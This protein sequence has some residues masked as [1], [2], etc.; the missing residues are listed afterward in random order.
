MIRIGLT[1]QITT[2]ASCVTRLHL[3]IFLAAAAWAQDPF[4][5][6]ETLPRGVWT[7]ETHLN[8]VPSGTTFAGGLLLPT[9]NQAHVTFES[10]CSVTSES[11]LE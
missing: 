3:L 5:L 4:E 7:F 1:I 11:A 8:Y 2:I 9:G 6:H 10:I